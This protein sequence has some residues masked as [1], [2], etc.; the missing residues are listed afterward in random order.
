MDKEEILALLA[1]HRAELDRYGV[2]SLAVFGSVARGEAGP[3]S[4]VDV[5][6]EFEGPATFDGYMD[7]KFFLEDLLGRTVDLVT[8]KAVRPQMRPYIE[9]EMVYVS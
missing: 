4:D 1:A 8:P 3:E 5:L 6:V 7:V 9:R 2:Q